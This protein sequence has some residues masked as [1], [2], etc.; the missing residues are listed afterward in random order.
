[1]FSGLGFDEDADD[2]ESAML[3]V[4]E[5]NDMNG[6]PKEKLFLGKSADSEEGIDRGVRAA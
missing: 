3:F 5:R 6:T 2:L 4:L 1:L